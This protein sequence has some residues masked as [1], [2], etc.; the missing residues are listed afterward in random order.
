MKA[1]NNLFKVLLGQT[2]DTNLLWKPKPILCT[3]PVVTCSYGWSPP[4]GSVFEQKRVQGNNLW[5]CPALLL[6]VKGDGQ[7]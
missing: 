6:V 1:L 3:L 7:N 2:Q 5:L 4:D